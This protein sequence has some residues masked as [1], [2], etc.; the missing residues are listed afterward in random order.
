[1]ALKF[2][3]NAATTL[4]AGIASGATS[5]TVATGAGALFPTLAAGDHFYATLVDSAQNIEI[6]KVTARSTDTLT[7]VRAQEGTSARAYSSGDKI[8]L[9]L[10]AAAL[11]E[12]ASVDV[13][14]TAP[15]SPAAGDLWWHSE[16]GSLYVY[17]DDGSS[18]Q[19]V[20]VIGAA[21][22]GVAAGGTTGQVLSKASASDY[23]TTWSTVS[24][25]SPTLTIDAKTSAYTVVAADLGKIINCTSGTF[26]V[27]LTAAA[28]LGAGFNCW[29]WNTSTTSTH[30]ITIDPDASETIDGRSTLVL[31]RGE[32]MQIICN[33]TNWTTGDQKKARAYAE[34]LDASDTRPTASGDSAVAIG[35]AAIA[36]S[37]NG[38]AL[39]WAAT[40]SGNSSSSAIGSQTTASVSYATAI[41]A[42][43]GAGGSQAV[44]GAGAMALGGSYASGTDS[45]A[46]AVANN[47]STYGARGANAVAIGREATAT[48]SGSVAIGSY[49][50]ASAI[51]SVALR[52]GQATGDGAIAIGANYAARPF[53]TGAY[54]IALGADSLAAQAG[55]IALSGGYSFGSGT[56]QTAFF[57][58]RRATTVA[59]ATVLTTTAAAAGTTN[60]V[61]LPN[62]SA[63]AFTGTVVARRKASEGTESAAW[64]IEGLIRR[65]ANAAS[66][67]L[68][69]S[70]VT[71]I[72]NAPGWTL[73][74]SADTTNG[75]LAVTATGAAS[76]NIR[77]VATVQTS[78]VIYA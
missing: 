60:Q 64:K 62:S 51:D 35:K 40:A 68:V 47:T 28:T 74:L 18:S 56:V 19:W 67:T 9:R 31:R 50:L 45:F 7:V 34:N 33:G 54:S 13:S 48:G 4:A 29:I 72:S 5:I 66:T 12:I 10:T 55:K 71:A 2:A 23:D 22:Q 26:T 69:A 8:E 77:W 30:A 17:Y 76:T 44:T 3:N 46:A 16:Q 14:T 73:A 36:S 58:L 11:A 32:G 6:V 27:S 41:G 70:T 42:N 57:I 1:M 38:V 25:S 63:Y 65:E 39:G 43:S 21:G 24:S 75:A 52:E 20:A 49:T 78:E 15:S 53:A 61:V 59:T 37:S